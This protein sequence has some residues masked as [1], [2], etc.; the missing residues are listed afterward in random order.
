MA[1]LQRFH[2]ENIN[3]VRGTSLCGY[4]AYFSDSIKSK[5][6]F[7][8]LPDSQKCKKCMGKRNSTFVALRLRSASS[9]PRQYID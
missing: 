4:V 8:R 1:R 3:R 7:D 6:D 9:Q 5:S 2:Q